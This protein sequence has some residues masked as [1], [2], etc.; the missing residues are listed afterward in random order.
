MY[1]L[2]GLG[3]VS[4]GAVAAG[5]AS[6]ATAG[7]ALGP[8]GAAAGAVV[9]G[10]LSAFA[11]GSAPSGPSKAQLDQMARQA[12]LQ[13]EADAAQARLDAAQSERGKVIK[14]ALF[15]TGGLLLAG[16]LTLWILSRRKG[17]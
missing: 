6:G 8:F 9:G 13:R 12:K 7:A 4:G 10:G 14:Y 2:H 1:R 5:A 15:G 3:K 11:G 16:A 17:K